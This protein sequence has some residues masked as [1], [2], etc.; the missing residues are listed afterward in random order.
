MS[1][2]TYVLVAAADGHLAPDGTPVPEGTAF[3]RILWDG[4][5]NYTPPDGLR[6]IADDGRPLWEPARDPRLDKTEFW[7]RFTP[8]EQATISD[9]AETRPDILVWLTTTLASPH[10]DL[11]HQRTRLPKLVAANVLSPERAAAILTP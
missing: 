11:T 5:A 2:N 3:N 9:A 10:V 4:Q 1:N 8:D 6:L 7:A